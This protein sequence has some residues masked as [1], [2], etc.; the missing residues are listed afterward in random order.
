MR[1]LLDTNILSDVR[2]G[3]SAALESWFARQATADL[4]IST[5]TLLELDVGVRRLTLRDPTAGGLLRVWLDELVR[6]MFAGRTLAVDELVALEAS[7]LQTVDPMP[8]MDA[9]IAATALSH[10][11]TLVTRN[12]ADVARSGV[13]LLDPWQL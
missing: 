11:L 4:A 10:G 7:R 9:L 13:A 1:Y 12:T 6:P 3:A 2:R 5:I 8:D